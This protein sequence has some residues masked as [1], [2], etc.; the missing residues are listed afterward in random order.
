MSEIVITC[1]RLVILPFYCLLFQVSSETF[2]FLVFYLLGACCSAVGPPEA[3]AAAG[4]V[5]GFSGG[6]W[7]WG[8]LDNICIFSAIGCRRSGGGYGV[9]RVDDN[10]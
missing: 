6:C 1:L 2:S 7:F 4:G 3:A 8:V 9:F 10:M 5:S